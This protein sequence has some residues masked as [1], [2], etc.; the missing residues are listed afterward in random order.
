MHQYEDW[1]TTIKTYRKSYLK[2][3]ET[4]MTSL[5]YTEQQLMGNKNGKKNNCLDISSDKL[6]TFHVGKPGNGYKKEISREKLNF[7]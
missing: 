2:Q 1:M 3:P 5:R 6:S 4:E 7:F